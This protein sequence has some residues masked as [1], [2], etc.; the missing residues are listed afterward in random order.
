[1][2]AYCDRCETAHVSGRR[3]DFKFCADCLPVI[4]AQTQLNAATVHLSRAGDSL[5]LAQEQLDRGKS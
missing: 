5:K 2:S 4:D 1:M 3:G